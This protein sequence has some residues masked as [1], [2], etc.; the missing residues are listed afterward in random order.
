MGSKSVRGFKT[1]DMVLPKV[2]KGAR[3]GIDVGRVAVAAKGQF[4]I[5]TRNG[6]VKDVGY[7]YRGYRYAGALSIP[8]MNRARSG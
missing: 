5:Q 6:A 3:A 2:T 8:G 1:G 4:S 7:Q